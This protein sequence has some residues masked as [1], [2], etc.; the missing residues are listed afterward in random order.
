[1]T[2]TRRTRFLT[3]AALATTLIAAAPA[4]FSE[5]NEAPTPPPGYGPGMMGGY[6]GGYG[7]GM[8]HG[9]GGRGYGPGMQ[10]GYNGTYRG[11]G[12][13]PGMMGG[14]GGG[15]GPGMM[16]GYGGGYGPGMMMGYG[17]GYGPGMMMGYGGGYGPGMM[18]GH[19]YGPGM[20]RGRGGYGPG[21]GYWGGSNL[22]KDQQ[23]KLDKIWSDTRE[24][25][26]PL[27]QQ[28]WQERLKLRNQIFADKPDNAEMEKTYKAIN[29]LREK[30]FRNS[31]KA[32]KEMQEIYSEGGK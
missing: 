22:T 13:G 12:Y 26:G 8:M 27:M 4:A 31:L 1:M 16:M 5:T 17:G 18:W 25:N 24:K 7:P 11:G 6:G 28:M 15:Y 21:A 23:E 9:Y 30:M 2:S 14:Y 10:R 19:G 29:G 3:A 20:M 32:R